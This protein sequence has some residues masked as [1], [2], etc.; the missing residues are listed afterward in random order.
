[1]PPQPR[2]DGEVGLGRLRVGEEVAAGELGVGGLEVD[3]LALGS[4]AVHA[5]PAGDEDTLDRRAEQQMRR[6]LARRRK[7]FAIEHVSELLP[8]QRTIGERVRNHCHAALGRDDTSGL[9]ITTVRCTGRVRLL[10]SPLAMPLTIDV[11]SS[12]LKEGRP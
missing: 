3:V 7:P 12:V 8:R 2:P 10:F 11:R 5:L 1:M 4:A 6:H 9:P